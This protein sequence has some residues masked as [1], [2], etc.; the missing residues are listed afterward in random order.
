VSHKWQHHKEWRKA[1]WY[2][3]AQG[4]WVMFDNRQY[5]FPQRPPVGGLSAQSQ[6][7]P[8]VQEDWWEWN[9]NVWEWSR[10]DRNWE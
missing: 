8:Y 3:Y 10:S 2:S 6:P 5:V 4:R 1:W 7:Q 9:G